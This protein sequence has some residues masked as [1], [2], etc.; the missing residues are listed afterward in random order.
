V[1]DGLLKIGAVICGLLAAG[2][3]PSVNKIS[4]RNPDLFD[5]EKDQM[6][7]V[8]RPV[9][10]VAAPDLYVK[11]RN[12]VI[13]DIDQANETGSLFNPDDERNYLFASSGPQT[14]GRY[15]DVF[16]VSNRA[17]GK[18]PDGTKPVEEQKK[19]DLA[20]SEDEIQKELLGSLPELT[21]PGSK[22]DPALIKGFKMRI[23]HRYSNGD[24][25]AML[26]RR[27]MSEDQM[28]D[29]NIESRIPYDRLSSGEPLTTRDL[30]D[31]KYRE[32]RNGELVDRSSSGW[33]DDYSLRISGFNEAKSK[34]ALELSDKQKQLEDA[35][36]KLEA[37]M[38]SFG[39]ERN[40]L[41]KQREDLTKKSEEQDQKV[42][43][44]EEKVKEQEATIEELKPQDKPGDKEK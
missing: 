13:K 31:V 41:S 36:K 1:K 2:C 24:V 10:S 30:Q 25:L 16:V 27:S 33:E 3:V 43:D 37:R 29:L 5:K 17:D 42:K 6:Q 28:H 19:D 39:D 8:S 9:G 21:P 7:G 11:E 26:N 22:T 14:V 15:L 4:G 23:V 20:K 12:V 32:N 35:T 38:K 40:Q 34:E 18:N 44:L